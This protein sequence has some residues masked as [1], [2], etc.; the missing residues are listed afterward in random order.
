MYVSQPSSGLDKRQATLQLYIRDSGTQTVKPAIIFRGKGNIT[1]DEQSQYDIKVDV[2]FQ[3]STWMDEELIIK[4]AKA[5]L[6]PALNADDKEMVLFGDIVGFQLSK[7]FHNICRMAINTVVDMLPAN[8]AD[9]VQPIDARCGMMMMKKK[10]G[11]AME[12]WL[13]NEANFEFWH[14]RIS[15]RMRRLLMTKWTSDHSKVRHGKRSVK[16]IKSFRKLF[17]KT[18]CLMT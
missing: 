9:K 13:E 11:E 18:V 2:H 17:E 15:A 10:I 8:P 14:D 5:T 6:I 7:E 12:K 3:P 4:W 1:L 16:T